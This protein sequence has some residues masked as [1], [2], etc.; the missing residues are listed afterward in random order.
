M[1]PLCLEWF[2][3]LTRRQD[4]ILEYIL[5]TKSKRASS[6]LRVCLIN[7]KSLLDNIFRF[8]CNQKVPTIGVIGGKIQVLFP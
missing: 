4:C 3:P 1:C 2:L 8:F 6:L 7:L 5:P